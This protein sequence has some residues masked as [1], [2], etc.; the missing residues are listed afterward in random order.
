MGE[1]E[2]REEKYE[3]HFRYNLPFNSY[4]FPETTPNVPGHCAYTYSIYPTVRLVSEPLVVLQACIVAVGMNSHIMPSHF[5]Q[6]QSEYEAE[7]RTALPLALTFIVGGAFLLMGV[8]F[9]AYDY[10]SNR[11]N[12][13]VVDAAAKFNSIVSSLFPENVRDRLFAD[14]EEKMRKKENVAAI[15]NIDDFMSGLEDEFENKQNGKPVCSDRR[16]PCT[17]AMPK[18]CLMFFVRNSDC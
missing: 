10:F 6:S 5:A 17:T 3:A 12:R 16:R 7:D 4:T 2:L 18:H 11:R 8:T 9:A 14:A 1:G 15:Q 13:K